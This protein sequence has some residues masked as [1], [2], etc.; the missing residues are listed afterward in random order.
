MSLPHYID[1][2]RLAEQQ[3]ELA[4]SYP[5]AALDRLVSSLH[6]ATGEVTFQLSF[7][8]SGDRAVVT[9]QVATRLPLTCQ[10]CLRPVS[11]SVNRDISL[12]VILNPDQVADL[13]DCYEPLVVAPDGTVA[14]RDI[15]EDELILELPVVAFHPL[16]V[17][18]AR[19]QVSNYGPG[20][21]EALEELDQRPNPFAVLQGLKGHLSK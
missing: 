18:P 20:E 4:G 13:P 11:W 10:R 21:T 2:Q 17:C 16:A 8:M 3:A 7:G 5:L 12:G 19:D 9:G 1:P 6:S 14:L 15:V